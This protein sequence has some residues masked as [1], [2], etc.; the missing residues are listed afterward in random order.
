MNIS[1]RKSGKAINL[2]RNSKGIFCHR[3]C[4]QLV[5]Q[6]CE[7]NIPKCI[8]TMIPLYVII[9]TCTPGF[10]SVTCAETLR[11]EGFKG[12]IIIATSEA[13]LPY[14]RPKLSKVCWIYGGCKSLSSYF[15]YYVIVFYILC[16]RIL[17]IMSSY[18]I[19]YVN[20]NTFLEYDYLRSLLCNITA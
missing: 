9:T 2:Q 10:A 8:L 17:Y 13:H 5:L 6:C 14:D 18:F 11:Q 12:K 16:H 4:A 19:Y 15:I 3:Q 20:A 1:E 7:Y